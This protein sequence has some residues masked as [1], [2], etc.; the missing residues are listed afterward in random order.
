[1]PVTSAPRDTA[2]CTANAPIPGS[3]DDQD[4]LPGMHLTAVAHRL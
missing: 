1:M 2:I 3:P 4:P